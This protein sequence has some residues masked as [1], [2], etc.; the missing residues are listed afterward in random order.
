VLLDS[1][2]GLALGIIALLAFLTIA[3]APL[4]IPPERDG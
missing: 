3:F 1:T 4:A 2:W